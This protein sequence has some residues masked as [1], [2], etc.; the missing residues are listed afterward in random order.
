ML[1]DPRA[2]ASIRL[3]HRASQLR[4]Y[5]IPVEHGGGE[6]HALGRVTRDPSTG[7][8]GVRVLTATLPTTITLCAR[9]TDGDTS[10]WLDEAVLKAPAIAAAVAMKTIV[11]LRAPEAPPEPVTARAVPRPEPPPEPTV[12]APDL[13]A[14]SL[15]STSKPIPPKSR[16]AARPEQ[17]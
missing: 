5:A 2:V 16:S 1:R 12:A 11:V 15:P 8:A 3:Q 6:A 17:E 9:S 13:A 14:S 7:A 4:T 10:D